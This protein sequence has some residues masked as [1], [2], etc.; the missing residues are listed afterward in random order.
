MENKSSDGISGISKTILLIITIAFSILTALA[1]WQLGPLGIF[2]HQFENFGGAQ[3]LIDLVIVCS[4][5][6]VWIWDDSKKTNRKFWP[7]LLIT[8]I[9]GSF[10]PLLY[11]L[12]RKKQ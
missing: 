9:A 12:F 8:L 3:V 5:M 1:L 10:G 7:W 4:L 2:K 11:L 6:L